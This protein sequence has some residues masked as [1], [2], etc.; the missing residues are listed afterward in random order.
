LPD[1]SIFRFTQGCN[2]G[3][4]NNVPLSITFVQRSQTATIVSVP[5]V[6]YNYVP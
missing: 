1:I 6:D 5:L 3:K 4:F 2:C